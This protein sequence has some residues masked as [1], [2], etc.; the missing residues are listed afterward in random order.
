MIQWLTVIQHAMSKGFHNELCIRCD[1]CVSTVLYQWYI[2]REEVNYG[3]QC[4]RNFTTH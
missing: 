1:F 2:E 4:D 3:I